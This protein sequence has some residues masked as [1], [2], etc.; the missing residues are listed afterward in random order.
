MCVDAKGVGE[1]GVD[2]SVSMLS[3]ESCVGLYVGIYVV[4]RAVREGVGR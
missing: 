2:I 3:V 4:G 1:Y